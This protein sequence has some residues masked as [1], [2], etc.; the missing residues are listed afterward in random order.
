[1][2]GC[3]IVDPEP[4]R[5]MSAKLEKTRAKMRINFIFS[6]NDENGMY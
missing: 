1:M 2:A 3:W 6:L 4:L 5:I